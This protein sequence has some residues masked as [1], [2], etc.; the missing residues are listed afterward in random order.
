STAG[1]TPST[2]RRSPMCS[3]PTRRRRGPSAREPPGGRPPVKLLSRRSVVVFFFV[4]IGVPGALLTYSS[5]A[6]S[7]PSAGD[8]A[9]SGAADSADTSA[10]FIYQRYQDVAVQL[11]SYAQRSM[12]PAMAGG[13][14][15]YDMSAIETALDDLIRVQNG[16]D[17]A[18]VTDPRGQ[19]VAIAPER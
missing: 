4:I 18:F 16:V 13:R 5:I 14:D 6:I 15:H 11:D 10:V 1:T 8:P 17:T 2:R 19:L 7:T 3:R 12:E 9:D